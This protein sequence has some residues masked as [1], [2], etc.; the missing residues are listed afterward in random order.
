VAATG[1]VSL[2]GRTYGRDAIIRELLHDQY[3]RY[4]SAGQ[5]ERRE[6]MSDVASSVFRK[7]DAGGWKPDELAGRLTDAVRGRHLLLWAADP[8]AQGGW[9]GARASGELQP[10]SLA[11]SFLNRS[12]TKLDWFLESSATLTT[13]RD[14]DDTVVT[15]KVTYTNTVGPDEPA[16]IAGPYPDADTVAGEYKGV[17]AFNVPGFA[18]D[19]ALDGV[20]TEI[21]GD[22]GP[23]KLMAGTLRVKRGESVTVTVRFRVPSGTS[24]VVEPSARFPEMRWRSGTTTWKDGQARTVRL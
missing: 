23:T 4:E 6:A 20:A 19:I 11:V 3:I 24:L 5:A 7:L 22:D 1:P 16:Y 9:A 2:D 10:G 18:R 14:S 21:R 13:R 8:A 12:G 15:A 17:V